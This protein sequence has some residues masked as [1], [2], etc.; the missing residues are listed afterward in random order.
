MKTEPAHEIA[1]DHWIKIPLFLQPGQT[2]I[3]D[4]IRTL[5]EIAEAKINATKD[6]FIRLCI[7]SLF[8][9]EQLGET[10]LQFLNQPADYIPALIS[11][12]T[13][14]KIKITLRNDM[15]PTI[16]LPT[17]KNG[18]HQ[19]LN[20]Q[21]GHTIQFHYDTQWIGTMTIGYNHDGKISIDIKT[22]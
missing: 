1:P 17:E 11:K 16:I 4:E 13:P 2:K 3:P 20:R 9:D 10:M 8:P 6:N 18:K 22:K 21:T 14:E 12:L 19:G 15:S 7:E 5:N